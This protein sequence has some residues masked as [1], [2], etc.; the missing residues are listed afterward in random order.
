MPMQLACPR[1]T[2]ESHIMTIDFSQ[3]PQTLDLA[4]LL[5]AATTL[6][7]LLL[8]LRKGQSAGT[9]PERPA[10]APAEAAA[11]AAPPTPTPVADV[12]STAALQVLALLQQEARFLDFVNEEL[13]GFSD[14]EIGAAA[15]V[16]HEGSRKAIR[17][18]FD[19]A[20]IRAEEEESRVTLQTGF[21]PS[22]VRL[23]GNVVGEAP[24]TGTLV[25]RGWKVTD[26]RLP[27]LAPEHDARIVAPAEVEL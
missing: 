9:E 6:V 25:H 13:A 21:D 23:T 24:F 8:A 7:C 2:E 19:L 17:N 11:E 15:R 16:V 12:S 5:L 26:V 27:T 20:P 14:A 10:Q 18:H 1:M 3:L 4:H 22:E